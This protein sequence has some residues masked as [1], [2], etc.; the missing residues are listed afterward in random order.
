MQK[1]LAAVGLAVAVP[2]ALAAPALAKSPANATPSVSSVLRQHEGFRAEVTYL[3]TGP[4]DQEGT[5]KVLLKQL[6]KPG[7][8]TVDTVG[9]AQDKAKCDG[10]EREVK[11]KIP[12]TKGPVQAGRTVQLDTSLVVNGEVKAHTS[13]DQAVADDSASTPSPT[14]TA[15][16][17]PSASSSE[18]EPS[19][20]PSPSA[21]STEPKHQEPSTPAPSASSTEPKHQESEHP[22][23]EHPESEHPESEHPESEHPENEHPE[24]E[25]SKKGEHQET[26][27]P[28]PSSTPT[29]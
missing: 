29:S 28:S 23:S 2:V 5:I 25:H 11:I 7:S 9:T 24:K 4:K 19:E 3:C 12:M 15:T 16:P 18:S 17:S 1:V 26:E 22:E 13:T 8:S 6:P 27:K 21:S 14:A 20:T 10:K